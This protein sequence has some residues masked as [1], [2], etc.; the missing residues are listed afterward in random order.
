[1]GNPDMRDSSQLLNLLGAQF[2]IGPGGGKCRYGFAPIESAVSCEAAASAMGVQWRGTER[3]SNYPTHC[4][5]YSDR[6]VYFN[7]G[8]GRAQ[9]RSKPLC[10]PYSF[11]QQVVRCELHKPEFALAEPVA[12][13]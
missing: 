10:S 4:Y 8:S 2:S 7:K 9:K 1:M 11:G 3:V 6:S 12:C 13:G 5:V